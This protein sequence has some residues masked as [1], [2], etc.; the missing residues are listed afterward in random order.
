[1]GSSLKSGGIDAVF[2]GDDILAMGALDACR[3]HGVAVPEE[4]GIIGFNDMAMASWP[5]YD[6]TTV[7][8][9]SAT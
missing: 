2:C 4:I 7:R 9:R 5:A 1:M 6:L 8:Q 3:E